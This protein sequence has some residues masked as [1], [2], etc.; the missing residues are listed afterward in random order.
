MGAE[1]SK[2]ELRVLLRSK[3]ARISGSDYAAYS[4]KIVATLQ[5]QQEFQSA[6]TIHCYVSINE[7]RE[8]NTRWLIKAM[9]KRGKQVVVPLT[10]FKDKT[11]THFELASF[12]DLV[13]RKWGGLEPKPTDSLRRH[14]S[15]LELVIVPMVGGDEQGHRIGYGAGFYD[16]F[17]KKTVCPAIGL[18]F[19]QNIIPILPTDD[20][21]VSL[22]K[23]ITEERVIERV[24][25]AE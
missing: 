17:L 22:D 7:R 6:K 21:D 20:H 8:V 10:H 25:G 19:E 13:P 5:Q 24:G 2:E 1:E 18:C 15:E 4:K 16:R 11:L 12:D 23:I 14:P 9:I 3:R